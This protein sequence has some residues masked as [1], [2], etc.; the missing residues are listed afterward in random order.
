MRHTP[1][2]LYNLRSFD[3][4]RNIPVW[5]LKECLQPNFRLHRRPLGLESVLPKKVLPGKM[6]SE[7][8]TELFAIREGILKLM[9][10]F[11]GRGNA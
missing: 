4:P 7:A 2:L 9:D 8:R 3:L 10:E 11:R 5:L 6:I 1:S